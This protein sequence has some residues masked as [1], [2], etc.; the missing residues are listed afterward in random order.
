MST[1]LTYIHGIPQNEWAERSLE[2]P[3][4]NYINYGQLTEGDRKIRPS[5]EQAN[6]LAAFYP[7][8]KQYREIADSLRTALYSGIH[9]PAGERLDFKAAAYARKLISNARNKRG[10]AAKLLL[11]RVS[12]LQGPDEPILPKTAQSCGRPPGK[13]LGVFN[14]KKQKEWE[15][16]MDQALYQNLLNKKLEDSAHHI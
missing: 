4:A 9:G 2:V 8:V 11:D 7:E 14:T 15:A 3:R 16:C 13:I 6:L 5:M 1:N 12:A 10:P